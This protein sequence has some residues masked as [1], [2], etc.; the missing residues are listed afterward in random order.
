MFYKSILLTVLLALP[1]FLP[2][3]EKVVGSVENEI[4]EPLAGVNVYW[5]N[6]H[7]GTSTNEKGAFSLSKTQK[8]SILIIKMIGFKTRS[9]TN[10]SAPLTITMENAA[11]TLDQVTVSSNRIG[12]ITKKSPVDV[13]VID[14]EM[15]ESAGAV[16][17]SESINFQSGVRLETDC[18]TCNYT[19][20]RMNGLGGGY[21]QILVN[22]RPIF[23][24]LMGLYGLEQFPTNWIDRIEVIRGGGSAIYGSGAIGGV[25]NIIPKTPKDN[26]YNV[27][28]QI[29]NIDGQSWE[30][31][32][33]A[34]MTISKKNTA[35]SIFANR[36]YSPKRRG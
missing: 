22:S 15:I 6:T 24:S 19:Q 27:K 31:N 29:R 21:T 18:Q 7:E 8:D 12:V 30:N 13:G 28:T 14:D 2:A 4:G 17:L 32:S 20:V 33:S 16:C 9:I 25:I 35:F 23:G 11:L 36:I 10:F 5:K 26:Y 34:S 1:F 3:Q